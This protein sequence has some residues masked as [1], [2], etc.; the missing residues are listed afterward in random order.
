MKAMFLSMAVT[1]ALFT[2]NSC[3]NESAL[4]EV[5]PALKSALLDF[6]TCTDS[7]FS[8]SIE[9]LTE[10]DIAGL[11]WMREEEKLAHDVYQYF[12]DAYNMIIFDRI[13][14]SESKH[15]DAVMRLLNHFG[16]EDPALS[17]AGEFSNETLQTL[18]N[19]MIAAGVDS[20]EALKAGA[21]IEETDIADL[22][23]SIANTENTDLLTVYGH[24]LKGSG[25]HLKAFVKTLERYG[26][27]YE[28]QVL[29]AEE[30]DAILVMSNGN[31]QQKKG[32]QNGEGT[33]KKHKGTKGK[34]GSNGKGGGR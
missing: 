29:S 3:S 33:G 1:I 15:A 20:L 6:P 30:F 32:A 14:A 5:D 2:F 28:P 27:T 11:L 23:T 16:L 25:Q 21:L 13:A 22:Q 4:A 17:A 9:D 24:L 8:T 26:F 18:Y 19:E 7:I 31:G 12:F 10:D 34:K